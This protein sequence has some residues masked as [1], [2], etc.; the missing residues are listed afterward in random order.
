MRVA[1]VGSERGE[2]ATGIQAYEINVV[3]SNTLF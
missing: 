2:E 3:V 1:V